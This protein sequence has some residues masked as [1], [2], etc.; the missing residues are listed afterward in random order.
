MYF[1]YTLFIIFPLILLFTYWAAREQ[2][3]SAEMPHVDKGDTG[4]LKQSRRV[5]RTYL[6]LMCVLAVLSIIGV[7]TSPTTS[8]I[9]FNISTLLL[10]AHLLG[11][12]RSDYDLHWDNDGITGPTKVRLVARPQTA[13]VRWDDI[14]SLETDVDSMVLETGAG[15]RVV[16][17]TGYPGH[18]TFLRRVREYRPDLFDGK[19][20][21]EAH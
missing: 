6:A 7:F 12:L 3:R 15:E 17:S 11:R 5:L 21:A 2:A 16:W 19:G 4:T 10:L 13:F 20:L 8:W 1:L 9:G 14:D 18:K